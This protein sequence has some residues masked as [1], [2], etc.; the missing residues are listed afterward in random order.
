MSCLYY[1]KWS[2]KKNRTF[3]VGYIVKW[4]GQ[5]DKVA[6]WSLKA[7]FFSTTVNALT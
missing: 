4:D 1:F 7:K 6:F 3:D 2:G 5:L